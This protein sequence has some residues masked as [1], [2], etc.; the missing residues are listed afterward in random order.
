MASPDDTDHFT[1]YLWAG[2]ESLSHKAVTQG[3]KQPPGGYC[4][5]RK[6][7]VWQGLALPMKHSRLEATAAFCHWT[8][9]ITCFIQMR[10]PGSVTLQSRGVGGCRTVW[11]SAP[12]ICTHSELVT[13]FGF[14]LNCPSFISANCPETHSSAY[15]QI[16]NLIGMQICF[17]FRPIQ[18]CC[19]FCSLAKSYPTLCIPMDYGPPGSSK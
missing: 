12:G 3:P 8:E 13:H 16:Y 19:C 6:K 1:H 18:N 9:T 2:C 14:S 17:S 5:K 15:Y 7:K 4:A 11:Q 10:G